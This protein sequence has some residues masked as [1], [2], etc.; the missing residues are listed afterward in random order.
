[1]RVGFFSQRRFPPSVCDNC[2]PE[3][4]N[5][6]PAEYPGVGSYYSCSNPSQVDTDGDGRGDSC[7][8]CPELAV[9][10]K[11]SDGDGVGDACDGC[12]GLA[13]P[14]PACGPAC[15]GVCVEARFGILN[16]S[17]C[18]QQADAD[19]TTV[20]GQTVK[21]R[22]TPIAERRTRVCGMRV[23]PRCKVERFR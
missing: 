18:G 2:P 1:M 11:D 20:V 17:H 15:R 16:L 21:L 23:A 22:S 9:A 5:D 12:P 14:Y 7:D 3:A 19:G 13:N 8:T 10:T 4:C 6:L